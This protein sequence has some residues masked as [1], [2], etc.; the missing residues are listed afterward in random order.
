MKKSLLYSIIII[1]VLTLIGLLSMQNGSIGISRLYAYDPAFVT[2]SMMPP[3]L[4]TS[5]PNLVSGMESGGPAT[6]GPLPPRGAPY[7]SWNDIF[8]WAGYAPFPAVPPVVGT[9][10]ND[11][12]P[13]ARTAYGL[14]YMKVTWTG[15]V[16]GTGSDEHIFLASNY[17][18]NVGSDA[19]NT[20][21]SKNDWSNYGYIRFYAY[22]SESVNGK[23][24]TGNGLLSQTASVCDVYGITRT[25]G[26]VVMST[27]LS[28]DFKFHIT[29]SLN[30]LAN[31]YDRTNTWNARYLSVTNIARFVINATGVDYTE[32]TNSKLIMY[33]DFLTLGA[34]DAVPAYGAAS[35]IKVGTARGAQPVEGA[36]VQWDPSAVNPMPALTPAMPV[37][38]Y[39]VFRSESVTGSPVSGHPYV[40]VGIFANSVTSVVDAAC[41]GGN[42]FC[43]K[44]LVL[45]NGPTGAFATERLNTINATYHESLI[46]E[47]GEVCGWVD[48]HPTFTV[49]PTPTYDCGGSACPS[50]M[51]TATSNPTITPTNTP[52]V[53]NQD[54]HVY[55]N[56]FNPNST[57]VPGPGQYK[58]SGRFYV[59]NIVADTKVSIFS[60][61]GMLVMSGTLNSSDAHYDD[62]TNP[63]RFWWDGLNTNGARVVS[64][65]YYVVMVAPDK[66]TSVKRLIICYKCD[67]YI[68]RRY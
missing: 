45:N 14:N 28:D 68:N 47:V 2:C 38:G 64:G 22:C 9:N 32:M 65:L 66:T 53:G 42:T 37:T 54:A 19:V 35:N 63:P 43:Y 20:F 56:P 26:P 57:P 36:N 40:S 8:V 27:Q 50:P 61:D 13:P 67:T 60:M 7:D 44:V 33:Y 58:G 62:K 52:I 30:F 15:N 4:I 24:I 1:S 17:F 12:L 21:T 59:D 18:E 39:H 46:D 25:V 5:G 11:A 23:G 10:T 29:A 34:K 55:P 6:C 31:S 41:A 49:T 3:Y 51:D 16:A 48:A